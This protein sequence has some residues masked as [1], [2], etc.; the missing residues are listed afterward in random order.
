MWLIMLNNL[1]SLKKT[2]LFLISNFFLMF[3]DFID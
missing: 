1:I 2:V 3:D